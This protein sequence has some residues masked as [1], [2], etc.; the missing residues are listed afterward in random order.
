MDFRVLGPLEVRSERGAVHLGGHKPR[1][2]L[3]VLLLHANEPVSSARL[4]EA[5]W[6]ED[7]T[8]ELRKSLQVSVSRLRKALDDPEIVATKGKSYEVRVRPGEL[9]A[10]RF[11]R[12]VDD[13]RRALASGQAEQASASLRQGLALWRGSPL[14]D[15]AVESFAE[16]DI[17]R[18]EEQRLAALETRV[19]A[20]LAAGRHA[21]LVGELRQ[22]V[23]DNPTRERLA[24]QLMLALYRCGRQAEA[25][26]AYRSAR[27]TLV[28]DIGVEPGP[29]LRRLHDAILQQDASLE[30]PSPLPDLPR[31]LDAATA[32]PLVGRDS[33]LDWLRE[34]WERAQRGTG[35]LVTMTGP[36]G[37]GRSRLAA[38]LAGDVHRLGGTV[39]YAAGAGP[40]DATRAALEGAREPTRPTLLVVDDA[41]RADEEVLGKLA[42][43]T[44]VLPTLPVLA[45][46]TGE[47]REAFALPDADGALDL[48]PLDAEAVREI[49]APYASD[50]E[51]EEVPVEWLLKTS[52]GVPRRVHELASH[53]ARHEAARRVDEVAGRTAAG[54]AGLRSM[55][56]EL[57][58]GVVELQR[59]DERL[60]MVEE[61]ETPVVCPFKGLAPFEVADAE[62]FFGRERLVAELVA[63]LVG[64]PLLGVVGPSG[65]GKSSVVRAGLL[66]ALAGGVL[67]GS[68]GWTQVL[69]RPGEHPLDELRRALTGVRRDRKIVLALDQFEEAF[70]ACRDED[71][72]ATF[73][74]EL[75]RVPRRDAGG[76][77]VVA[78]RADFYGRCAAYPELSHLLAE[79]HVLVGS[80]L[81]VE[82]R[83]AVIGPAQRVVLHVEP[84]LVDALVHDVEDEPGAL[85]LLSTALLELWQR[86]DGRRLRLASYEDTGG[87]QG[88]VARLAE[89][90]FGRL[91]E[92]QQAVARTVLLRLAEVEIEG[93]V[94]RRRLPLEEV[95]DGRDDVAAVIGLLADARVLTL[96]AGSVE[97]AHEALLREWPRLRDWIEDDRE[98]LRIHRNLS[99]AARE[100]DRLG[101]DE[102]ALYRGSRLAEAREWSEHTDL[103]ATDLEREFLDASLGRA[104]RERGARRR[105][106]RLAFGALALGI[107]AIGAVALVALDQRRDAERQRN[108]AVSRELA[109]QSEKTLAVDPELSVRLALWALDTAPTDEAAAALRGATLAFHPSSVLRADRLD[110]NTA[111]Y[112]PDGDRVVTG[113][114]TGVARVWDV[115]T[116]REVGRLAGGQGA[117]LAARYAPDGERIAVGFEDGTVA[118]TDPALTAP[119]VVLKTDGQ[120]VRSVAFSRDGEHIA[121]GLDDGTVR[122]LAANGSGPV[123]RLR[124][125]L[126]PVLGVDITA[127]GSRVVSSGEDGS[128][129][130]WS[131]TDG[132]TGQILHAGKT[133]ETDVAF[134][135]DGRRILGVGHDR[136]VRMWDAQTG[137]EE[138]N[139][140]GEG[141]LL[142]AAA[143]SRDGRRFAAGGR[144]GVIRVWSVEGGPPV[145]VLRGQNARVYDVGFGPT[146]HR[147]VSAADDGTVRMWDAGRTQAWTVPSV[148]YDIEFNRDG[149][150]VS[151]GSKDGTMRIWDPAT[152][153]VRASL[154]GPD[155]ITL[156]KFSPTAD[157]LVI[158]ASSSRVRLWHVSAKSAEVAARLPKGRSVL[159]ARFD[160]TG[161][162]LVYADNR[163]RVAVR[164]LRSGREVVLGG[165]PKVVYGT[166]WSPDGEHVFAVPDRDVLVWRVDRPARPE[167]ALKGH[168]GPVHAMDFS[169]DGRILTAGADRTVRIWDASGKQLV[170]MRGHEDEL[171]TALFTADDT[172]VLSTSQDGSV[173]L[174]DARTGMQLAVVHSAEGELY[175]VALS[176]D[177]K[178]ATLGKGEVVRVFPCDV[179]GSLD[180]VRAL[181]LS[182]SPRPLTAE[183]RQQFLAAAE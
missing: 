148:T 57:A 23:A 111:A 48:G 71:E 114:T 159:D 29:E 162:R 50:P 145:A 129:R 58:G 151:S 76:V 55:E 85:P 182:R 180:R 2:V 93:G 42:D 156:G 121:A 141:R 11:E 123:Q 174:F 5:V 154:P 137:A 164:D 116:H 74:S 49:A 63:R 69:I 84:E 3:A 91:D 67:P 173:R 138:A 165:T 83:R 10:E 112:S 17:A 80:M 108:I 167:F 62:Y 150:M 181:A 143:F 20:D 101:R 127:D 86:R 68:E 179:C 99:A 24:G 94:E 36:H 21:A 64:T 95:S 113:G 92:A 122:L 96:S 87:V 52:D 103:R 14:A 125:H 134:S 8:P 128:V 79:N 9:D 171:T 172:Q 124:G 82:L 140:S 89:D 107:V 38:E 170:V 78:L 43:L 106:L 25:L 16:T 166:E 37:I 177:G 15:L 31:E 66:P 28:D 30:P 6:G 119:Q 120:D 22:L 135:P 13:G 183:E 32:P 133:P 18:L 46:A 153:R 115:A 19:D 160:A 97:F 158:S 81:H 56:D 102:G 54:R 7:E 65:S 40:P 175:D 132:G 147:V 157:T 149:R 131:A 163:G 39:L 110:A 70:T 47:R 98:D 12:L 142:S 73:I 104:R 161:N 117:V 4:V 178:I 1:A 75:A 169:R 168:D 34:R 130:L 176:P 41:D 100:W 53:W 109:L 144:D 90:G 72:R 61:Q 155:G 146:S 60:A 152:G 26:E 136:R 44:R 45:L 27:Q 35:S 126:G 88:A 139:L 105:R 33:E 51:G 59:A 77:V 118:V